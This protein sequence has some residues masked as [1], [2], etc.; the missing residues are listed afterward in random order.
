M[1]MEMAAEMGGGAGE[2]NNRMVLK[3]QM[4]KSR[5]FTRE[6]FQKFGGGS[7]LLIYSRAAG[8]QAATVAG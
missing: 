4:K 6:G 5:Q 8:N 7:G 2:G 1:E 3:S